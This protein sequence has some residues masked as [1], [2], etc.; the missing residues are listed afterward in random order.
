MRKQSAN[1]RQAIAYALQPGN[2]LRSAARKYEID[3]GYL[4]DAVKKL[5]S[6]SEYTKLAAR[7]VRAGRDRSIQAI[8]ARCRY[9][10]HQSRAWLARA[11]AGQSITEIARAEG[12]DYQVLYRILRGRYDY[13]PKKRRPGP[14]GQEPSREQVKIG[15]ALRRRRKSRGWTLDEAGSHV[16]VTRQEVARWESGYGVSLAVRLALSL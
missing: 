14:P 1:T 7:W 16:G 12:V 3:R 15:Q 11:Q 5:L 13:W 9:P 10:E 6:V 2:T 4:R 8:Q